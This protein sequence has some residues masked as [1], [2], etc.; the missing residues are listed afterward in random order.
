M[1]D[2]SVS[3]DDLPIDD[4]LQQND[5]DA[6]DVDEDEDPSASAVQKVE[7]QDYGIDVDFEDLDDDLKD[8]RFSYDI[9]RYFVLPS[10]R[11]GADELGRMAK[12]RSKNSYL[13]KS[14]RSVGSWIAWHQI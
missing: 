1:T 9:T 6:M 7:V 11:A 12:N 5:P 2:E 3:L 13:R 8:V 4:T 10:W 14:R